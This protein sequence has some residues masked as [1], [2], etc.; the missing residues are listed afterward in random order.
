MCELFRQLGIAI[1]ANHRLGWIALGIYIKRM[2]SPCPSNP[3]YNT[4]LDYFRSM[5]E[6]KF[7]D[8]FFCYA[9]DFRFLVFP[10]EIGETFKNIFQF[11]FS[12]WDNPKKIRY[13][14][15]HGLQWF[16]NDA[17]KELERKLVMS[18]IKRAGELIR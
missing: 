12:L 5:G 17:V 8:D 9:E 11:D 2:Q 4:Y 16:D 10:S 18:A 15:S 6:Y 7:N 1:R 13:M 14:H 3:F